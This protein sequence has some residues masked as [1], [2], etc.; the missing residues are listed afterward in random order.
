MIEVSLPYDVNFYNYNN[1][2][3]IDDKIDPENWDGK[4]YAGE[5]IV[6]EKGDRIIDNEGF[7]WKANTQGDKIQKYD[8]NGN[9]YHPPVEIDLY[10]TNEPVVMVDLGFGYKYRCSW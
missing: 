8:H 1:Y 5:P 7:E 2:D 10:R 9:I 3:K 4:A 6:F